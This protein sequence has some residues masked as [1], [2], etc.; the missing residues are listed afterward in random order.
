MTNK[1]A[2][3]TSPYLQQ[4]A[5][6]PVHWQEW[7][8]AALQMSRESGKPIL[9]SV[10][11][12]ACHWCHVMAHE[13]FEDEGV[14]ALMNELFVNIKVDREERP[15]IDQIYQTAHA[16]LTQR[17]GGWPLTMFLT[18]ETKP[19]FGGTYFPKTARYG[20]PGFGD[21][22]GRLSQYF[23]NHQSEI[24]AQNGQLISALNRATSSNADRTAVA[25]FNREPIDAG[26][27][28][29]AQ[30]FDA[31]RGGFGAAPK[32]PHP[33]MIDFCLRRF[34]EN[35]NAQNQNAAR[36]L[37]CFTLERMCKGGIFDQLGGGF[38]RYSVDADWAI[39]HFEKMLYDNAQLIPV[40]LHAYQ[41]S[42]R[43]RFL[44][45]VTETCDYVLREMTLPD[46]GFCSSQDADSEGVEGKFFVWNAAQLAE[47]LGASDAALA[48]ELFGVS[49]EGNFDDAMTV[50][51]LPLPLDDVAT[52]RDMP[53]EQLERQHE[54]IR[55]RLYDARSAR[56]APDRDDKVLTSW[57][58]LMLRSLA[59]A[60]AALERP[61]YVDAA[62]SAAEF[63]LSELRPNGV[64][65]RTW[66]DGRAKITGFLEDVAF[67]CDA[68]ITLYEATGE[69]RWFT[70]AEDLAADM[71]A[72]FWS[73]AEGFHD[74]AVD[75]ERL[76]VRPRT[77]D[78][79][80]LPAGQSVAAIALL[81]LHAFTGDARW[82]EVAMSVVGPLAAGVAR[83]PLAL[84][85]LAQAL[86]LAVSP[87]REVAIIGSADD[88]ATRSLVRE[89]HSRF[90]W[91]TVLAWGPDSDG[92][93]GAK[94]PLLEGRTSV[95]GRPAAY[96]CRNF[97]CELPVTDPEELRG[98]L[99]EERSPA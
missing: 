70:A 7:G 9:L 92:H 69:N 24:S 53:L 64:V 82:R 93:G 80:P 19:F 83:A 49:A 97:A 25:D 38:A 13:S 77:L 75:S 3:S 12:S 44:R 16:M 72:R 1:L 52:A 71:V 47:V 39:P 54:S 26:Y 58:A 66:K 78:D 86:D 59:E 22:L 6:N 91:S 68:L 98:L 11:Y 55:Q 31:R 36:H 14:A 29:I 96:V 95:G 88:P 43:V 37:A 45:I 85:T 35:G 10:G 57:N 60:G 81:R 4:H 18:P 40:Y 28:Q 50:L 41:L 42:G 65:L 17:S 87:P 62:R 73:P 46:G 79:N 34:A 2:Q 48:T 8:P 51:S 99:T 30:S 74:T 84:A 5:D 89:L 33:E 94:V 67:L 20:L 21:L 56:I 76:L 23:R 63:L 15:D 61:D 32:F 90:D 27:Q